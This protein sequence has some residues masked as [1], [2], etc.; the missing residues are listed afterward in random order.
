MVPLSGS[1][2]FLTLGSPPK[3][4][5]AYVR[6]PNNVYGKNKFYVPKL[7]A[8]LNIFVSILQRGGCTISKPETHT[9]T[10]QRH[11]TLQTVAIDVREGQAAAADNWPGGRPHLREILLFCACVRGGT[12]AV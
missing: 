5:D 2:M 7:K 11:N 3:N 6:F 9:K 12:F 8:M 1:R 4:E 10:P